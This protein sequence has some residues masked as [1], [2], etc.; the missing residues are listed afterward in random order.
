MAAGTLKERVEKL[1]RKLREVEERF[2][3]QTALWQRDT[4]P[5]EQKDISRDTIHDVEQ[6]E[7]RKQQIAAL[8]LQDASQQPVTGGWK[9]IVGMFDND[10]TIKDI[11]EE[12][13]KI[14]KNKR[15]P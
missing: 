11:S 3:Q 12:G 15:Q 5:L 4:S 13:R 7:Q 9:S 8:S 2:E 10:P 14:R 1:E 6:Q